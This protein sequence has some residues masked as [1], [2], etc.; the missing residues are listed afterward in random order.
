MAQSDELSEFVYHFEI[1][2]IWRILLHKMPFA[3]E[4]P[5][6]LYFPAFQVE[7]TQSP[8]QYGRHWWKIMKFVGDVVFLRLFVFWVIHSEI[9]IF[10]IITVTIEP[11]QQRI[12]KIG[13]IVFELWK[14]TKYIFIWTHFTESRQISVLLHWLHLQIW[15]KNTIDTNG[16]WE[17]IFQITEFHI[18]IVLYNKGACLNTKPQRTLAN[19]RYLLNGKIKIYFVYFW[20]WRGRRVCWQMVANKIGSNS[21]EAHNL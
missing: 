11:S 5:A 7:R 12:I 13:K 15:Y 1:L 6:Q 3:R 14:I 17:H 4:L 2:I 18:N 16:K 19:K 21:W 10:L 9:Y 8:L 20:T